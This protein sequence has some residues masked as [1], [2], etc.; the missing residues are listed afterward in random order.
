M[1]DTPDRLDADEYRRE[2]RK[3]WTDG[4]SREQQISHAIEGVVREVIE[5][6]DAPT[7]DEAG[8][9]LYFVAMLRDVLD[10][11][12]V[13]QRMSPPELDDPMSDGL[14]EWASDLLDARASFS[15]YG[16]I[17]L[18]HFKRRVRKLTFK[19]VAQ[20]DIHYRLDEVRARNIAKLRERHGE[21]AK[22]G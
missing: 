12:R 21:Q 10:V 16:S 5:Y 2:A 1:G 4:L 9:V 8:D 15:F 3:T 7:A 17:E 19:I 22:G 18:D 6:V 14:A 20:I 13:S 11:Q